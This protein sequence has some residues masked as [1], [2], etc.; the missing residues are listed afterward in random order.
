MSHPAPPGADFSTDL[1]TPMAV[2]ILD[3]GFQP[4]APSVDLVELLIS[5]LV[6]LLL[7]L[8]FELLP[9]SLDATPVGGRL[10]ALLRRRLHGVAG[11]SCQR[12]AE[13]ACVLRDDIHL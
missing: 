11:G 9:V 3:P 1:I 13:F 10:R 4:I 7:G 6:P 12:V 8:A 5:E 2:M